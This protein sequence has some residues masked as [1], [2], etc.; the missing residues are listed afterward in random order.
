MTLQDENAKLKARAEKAEREQ[1]RLQEVPPLG[2]ALTPRTFALSMKL[3]ML[4]PCCCA[5]DA[6]QRQGVGRYKE[7]HLQGDGEAQVGAERVQGP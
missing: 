4:A 1:Q 5:G 6:A 7:L 3:T 2:L